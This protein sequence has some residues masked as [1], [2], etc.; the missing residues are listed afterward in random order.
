MTNK[1]QFFV[2]KSS[3]IQPSLIDLADLFKRQRA[4]FRASKETARLGHDMN[5]VAPTSHSS[6]NDDAAPVAVFAG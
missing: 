3:C 4:Y 5:Y 2:A 1:D 6:S